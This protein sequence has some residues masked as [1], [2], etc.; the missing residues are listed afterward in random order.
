MADARAVL[1]LIDE[2][3]WR[4]RREGLRLPASS[5]I[6]AVRAARAVGLSDREVLRAA[7]A[8]AVVK[9]ARERRAFDRAFDGFF[10]RGPR[11][12]LRERLAAKGFTAAELDALEELLRDVEGLQSLLGGEA[13]I[14][15]IVSLA[16]MTR[17]LDAMAGPMQRGF[18]V[19][20]A[21]ERAGTPAARR[22]LASLRTAL[23]DAIGARADALADALARELDDAEDVVRQ[24]VDA[25]AQREPLPRA[26]PI[27]ARALSSLD[28][29]ASSTR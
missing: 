27:A 11:A 28:P 5:A 15:R 26:G 17:L 3:L 24:R 7:L 14:D 1:R 2:L 21:L 29:G 8:C 18:F 20:R 16:S 6:D 13:E 22:S 4:M 23:R 12:S 9:D 10:A 25:R 19:H